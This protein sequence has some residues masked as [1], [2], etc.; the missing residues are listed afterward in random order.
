MDAFTAISS[1]LYQYADIVSILILSAVGLIIIFGMMGI[2]NMA[3]GEMMMIGAYVTSFSY[4]AGVPTPLAVLLGGLAAALVGMI[5]ERLVVRRFYGQLLSSLVVTWG[6]SLI[7]SQGALLAFGSLVRSVPTPFGSF[8]V[9]ELSFS[10]YRVFLFL[11]GV[12][13][14]LA[15]W[16]LFRFTR[17]GLEARATMQDA[18]MAHALGIDTA[19]IYARVFGLGTGLAGLAGGLLALTSTIGPYYG[20][21]YTTQAFI[22]VVVGG[23]AELVSGL[24]AS[25]LSLGA[26]RTI[27]TNQFNIL[28][29]Q[30]AML[31]FAFVV[32]R[33]MPD[34]ISGW[35]ARRRLRSGRR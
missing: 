15:V 21:A 27:A 13:I 34:G 33:L 3:H 8:A 18:T 32:I 10:V 24:L 20:Q 1:F 28:L 22:T 14:L 9:G 31:V 2:I 12:A 6:V 4:Y 16:A 23:G 29:G 19:R 7:L 17:F 26:V 5:L 30:M 35:I 25:A 11:A